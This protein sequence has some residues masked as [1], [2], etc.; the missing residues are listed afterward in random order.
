MSQAADADELAEAVVHAFSE[1]DSRLHGKGAFPK[2]EFEALYGAVVRY[3]EAAA[4]DPKIH[5]MVV[6]LVCSLREYLQVPSLRAPEQVVAE[7]DRM[8]SI[9]LTGQDP[10]FDGNEPPC[11]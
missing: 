4:D 7:A 8:E 3:A 10:H 5:R 6:N 9:L 11:C 1:F 2:R